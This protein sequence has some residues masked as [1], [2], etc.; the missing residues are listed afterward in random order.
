MRRVHGEATECVVFMGRQRNAS[1]SSGGNGTRAVHREPTGLDRT[2]DG[3]EDWRTAERRKRPCVRPATFETG[4]CS[5]GGVWRTAKR[6][7]RTSYG[8][9]GGPVDR[10]GCGVPQNGG[11]GLVLERDGRNG[12]HVHWEGCGIPQNGTPR[13]TVHLH[14]R[15]PPASMGYRRPP[16]A[17]TGSCSSSL[18]RALLHRLLFNQP[19][20]RTPVQPPL[21]GLLFIQPSTVYC[22]FCPPWGGP[23]H[24]AL[25][26]VLFIQPQPARSIG[27]L[28]IQRQHH[29]VLF[30]HPHRELFIQTPQQCSLFIQRQHRS[31]SVSCSSEGIARSGSV[32]NHRSIAWVQ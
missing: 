24:P 30:I 28:F 18:H 16:P 21:H 17:S 10:E 2:T 15:P 6:R 25:H 19:S 20:T 22:S 13:D 11:N 1:C 29:G 23:V 26:G 31:A 27:V 14:R 5:S 12:G 8:R 4:S 32:S 3:N 7:K 9:N